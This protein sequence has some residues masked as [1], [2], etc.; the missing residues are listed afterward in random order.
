MISTE[1]GEV[2]SLSFMSFRETGPWWQKLR[3]IIGVTLAALLLAGC[4]SF[5]RLGY[6]QGPHLAYWW[7]DGYLDL[8]GEQSLRLRESLD[9]W[10]DWHRRTQPPDYAG[11]L[12]RAQREVMQPSSPQA[13][14]AWRDEA[15]RRLDAAIERAAP[16]AARLLVT[17]KPEQLQHMERQLAKNADELR[18]DFAQPDREARA[19]A[20]FKRTLER[21]ETFYGRL[22]DAQR[23]RLAQLLAA[24]PFDADRWLAERQRRNADMMRTLADARA[25][26][27]LAQAQAAVRVLVERALRSPRADYR[28]YQERL[29]QDNCALA[30]TMHN[31]AT[32]EQR[33][34]ARR[35]LRGW[36]E[37]LRILA[38]EA[39]A[40]AQR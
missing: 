9:E 36:E 15:Q 37:D 25:S 35:K 27:D 28:A 16:A 7:A 17:I 6:G 12:A 20:S 18:E 22:D 8:D 10:F 5:L 38:A 40:T 11:L 24:S 26:G 14:C 33:M 30:A 2:L 34:H 19:Q 21:Y 32:T 39:N 4:G 29:A 3:T 13:M 1:R 31:L 23:T